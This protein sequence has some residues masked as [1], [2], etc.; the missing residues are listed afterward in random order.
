[1]GFLYNYLCVKVYIYSI[2]YKYIYYIF[3]Y[4]CFILKDAYKLFK[5]A[6]HLRMFLFIICLSDFK[7][8]N[9]P[10]LSWPHFF[11]NL[12]YR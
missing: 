3:V 12:G 7:H 10:K 11:N 5:P 2:V 4:I 1:M 8:S 6:K 9:R